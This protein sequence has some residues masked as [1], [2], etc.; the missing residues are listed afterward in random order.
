LHI[1]NAPT[2]LMK[3]V[4]YGREYKYAHDYAGNFVPQEYL[5]EKIKDKKIYLPGKNP[6]EAKIL[7]RLRHWWGKR[8]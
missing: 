8:F 3:T 2:K 1:R 7:D 5:P 6:G 4:G